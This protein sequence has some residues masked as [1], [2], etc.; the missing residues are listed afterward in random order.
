[1]RPALDGAYALGQ[2]EARSGR[3]DRLDD[4]S[5]VLDIRIPLQPKTVDNPD[6]VIPP[7]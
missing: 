3:G 4:P 5:Q 2:G 6:R 7:G 1:M